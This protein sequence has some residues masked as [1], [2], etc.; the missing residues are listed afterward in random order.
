MLSFKNIKTILNEKLVLR[1]KSAPEGKTVFIASSDLEDPKAAGN[2][3]FTNKDFIK[4]LG[5]KWNGMER[6]WETAALD[7]TQANQFVTDAI[8]KLNEFNKEEASGSE[9]SEYSGEDLEDRFKKFVE[10]LKS[11]V[12]NVK[13]SKEYQEYVQF[14]KRFRNYSFNNQIL[15]FIQRKNTSIVTGKQIGRAHV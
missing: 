3:T 9:I 1:K 6:R 7:E 4:S 5:F 10:L 15:I 13:N 11:G 12:M 2:E 8:K 14:Q